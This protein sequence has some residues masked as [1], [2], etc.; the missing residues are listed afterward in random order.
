MA[1]P[2]VQ[3]ALHHEVV[4]ALQRL[5]I[6]EGTLQ[7][8]VEQGVIARRECSSLDPPSFAG[9]TQWALTHRA[10]RE[11]LI[12]DGWRPDDSRNYSTV[13][14][15]E[16]RVALGVAAG[17]ERT[18]R[19]GPHDPKT[20]YPKGA[21]TRAVLKQNQLALFDDSEIITWVLLYATDHDEVRIEV[22]CPNRMGD[23]DHIIGWSER[24][25]LPAVKLDSPLDDLADADDV[26]EIDVPIER[27]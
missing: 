17:D 3:R 23:D 9:I 5:G 15:R 8:A 24:I 19:T 7:E 18:G 14:N 12:P 26:T 10:L 2:A 13:V 20:R 11:L 21:G 4:A 22:S 6:A 16:H 25:I 1:E 27:K